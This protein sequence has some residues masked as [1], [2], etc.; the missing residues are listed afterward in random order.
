MA[1]G[2][3]KC[4]IPKRNMRRVGQAKGGLDFS[5][6]FSLMEFNILGGTRVLS[7]DRAAHYKSAIKKEACNCCGWSWPQLVPA[8]AHHYVL[9]LVRR[10]THACPLTHT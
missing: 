9:S 8:S 2:E 10:T 7:L 4:V 5:S 3:R 1:A 6:E